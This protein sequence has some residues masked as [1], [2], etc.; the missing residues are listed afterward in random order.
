MDGVVM[1]LKELIGCT[2]AKE[3]VISWERNRNITSQTNK[4]TKTMELTKGFSYFY[5][6]DILLTHSVH[7]SLLTFK[8]YSIPETSPS[9]FVNKR[10]VKKKKE[11]LSMEGL[12]NK[13]VYGQR[14]SARNKESLAIRKILT[15]FKRY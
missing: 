2:L 8:I 9:F 13:C 4:V 12:R 3:V 6:Q 15:D 11:K 5:V 14:G 7:F 10:S 1:S